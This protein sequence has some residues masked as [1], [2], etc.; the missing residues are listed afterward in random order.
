MS[1]FPNSAAAASSQ[2][3]KDPEEERL[4]ESAKAY[5]MQADADGQSVY[6]L[7]YKT[8]YSMLEE[9]PEDV[10]NHPERLNELLSSLKKHQFEGVR[11]P[12]AT[13]RDAREPSKVHPTQAADSRRNLSL[14][15]QPKPKSE[16][17]VER[18]SPGVT[19]TTTTVLQS[20][21]PTF[22]SVAKDNAMWKYCGYGLPDQEAFLL[23]QSI[24]KLARDKSL[25]EVRFVG[26]I[27]GLRGN[28][29]VVSSKRWVNPN[30][31]EKIFKE[32][33]NMPKPP[34]KNTTVDVQAE[35]AYKGCNRQSFWVSA[36]AGAEWTLLPDT[37]P[38]HI[39]ASRSI[40]KLFT[41]DLD[42]P[43]IVH[44]PFHG[45]DGLHG[46]E[47]EY[48]RAQLSRLVAATFISPS[49]ALERPEEDEGDEDDDDELDEN[50]K[51]KPPKPAKYQALTVVSKEYSPDVENGVAGLLDLEQWV[52]SEPFIYKDGRMSK[53]PP[54]PEEDED[55]EPEDEPV[56]EE[57]EEANADENKEEEPEEE[58]RDL[59]GPVK[60]DYLYGVISVPKE[61]N[62]EE[63]EEEEEREERPRR[64]TKQE[65]KAAQA[66]APRAP[67]KIKIVSRSKHGVTTVA[68][69]DPNEVVLPSKPLVGSPTS[70]EEG[71]E[72]E[73]DAGDNMETMTTATEARAR[74]RTTA[75][76]DIKE[77]TAK[78][79][80][81]GIREDDREFSKNLHRNTQ[82]GREKSKI[83]N[84]LKSASGADFF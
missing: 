16:T 22:A 27:F 81:I 84:Q 23:D 14:L 48:L 46:L 82:K 18:P 9:N 11:V 73:G 36:E 32:S 49:G 62:P 72:V 76:V 29:L 56:D 2:L 12:T 33:N 13:A 19:V 37:T 58:E 66:A 71:A 57:E 28:Y 65:L 17:K 70:G 21:G 74:L 7:L 3:H 52:H 43:V 55:E 63:E 44:P 79:K 5:L 41:G 30:G 15:A 34:R 47:S 4:F 60:R 80:R 39:N 77:V 45:D 20:S 10:A 26:K 1:G 61:P 59:F 75:K 51:P 42:A 24:S 68:T 50:G 53:V 78:V 40:N 31:N 35:P 8:V 6:D 83:K 38:Q 25:E 54:K 69:V 64:M 67:R